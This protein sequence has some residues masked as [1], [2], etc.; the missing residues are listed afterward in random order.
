MH[1]QWDVRE[2][3]DL[4]F[5]MVKMFTMLKIIIKLVIYID[6]LLS[7]CNCIQLIYMLV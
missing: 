6:E 4:S 7:N 1:V 3:L 5:L 2:A